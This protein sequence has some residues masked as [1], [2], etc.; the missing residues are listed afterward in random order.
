MMKRPAYRASMLV[1][2][3]MTVLA[4]AHSS[5]AA[6]RHPFRPILAAAKP[7]VPELMKEPSSIN[8]EMSCWRVVEI[9]Q[10]RGVA[11]GPV[12]GVW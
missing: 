2:V 11:P 4:T 7:A 10:P 5:A 8:D 9:F 3:S 12:F 6:Q 1:V